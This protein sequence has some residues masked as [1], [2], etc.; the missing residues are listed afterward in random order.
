MIML[1]LNLTSAVYFL[2][3]PLLLNFFVA[4]NT[5]ATLRLTESSHD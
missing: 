4:A 3:Q 5:A 2:R 1:S